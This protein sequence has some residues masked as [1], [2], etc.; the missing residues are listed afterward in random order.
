MLLLVLSGFIIISLGAVG[1]YVGRIF[2]QVKGR[3]L[4]M[5]DEDRAGAARRPEPTRRSAAGRPRAAD[6][7]SSPRAADP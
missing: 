3:P 4:F 5:V 7:T 1:L 6:G 2:D